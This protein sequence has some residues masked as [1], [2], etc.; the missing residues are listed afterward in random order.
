MSLLAVVC[1]AAWGAV[2]IAGRFPVAAQYLTPDEVAA[3]LRLPRRTVLKLCRLGRLPAEKFGQG[4]RIHAGRLAE[5]YAQAV[6]GAEW[7]FM[8]RRAPRAC[9]PLGQPEPASE[10]PRARGARTESARER[11]SHAQAIA[12]RSGSALQHA[13]EWKPSRAEDRAA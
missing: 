6:D 7:R 3:G 12:Q 5:L 1:A 13:R 8:V 9:G 11:A 10:R 2:V 4:W